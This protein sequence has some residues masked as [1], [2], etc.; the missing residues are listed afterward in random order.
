MLSLMGEEGVVTPL[1]QTL[2]SENG[3]LQRLHSETCW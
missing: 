1:H 2:C 3:A